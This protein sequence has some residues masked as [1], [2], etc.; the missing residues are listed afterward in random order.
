M[1]WAVLDHAEVTNGS[2]TTITFT[3]IDQNYQHLAIFGSGASDGRSSSQYEY[4][5]VKVNFNNDTTAN[6]TGQDGGQL[7]GG[8]YTGYGFYN[9]TGW[10]E[11]NMIQYGPAGTTSDNFSTYE[12]YIYCYQENWASAGAYAHP[13]FYSNTGCTA[14]DTSDYWG[15][16]QMYG[17][18]KGITA[19]VTEI[20]M[21][22]VNGTNWVQGTVMTLYGIEGV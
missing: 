12:A 9:Q 17:I 20:D 5:Y 11:F 2:T 6:Y 8:Y 15:T 7:A 19:A 4:D 18:A 14:D 21:T 16:A 3:S 1:A 10:S 22:L 13:M